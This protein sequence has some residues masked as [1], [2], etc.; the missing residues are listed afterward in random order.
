MKF[1]RLFSLFALLC[2]VN[3]FAAT[4]TV[5][6]SVF[7][8]PMAWHGTL[9]L[10]PT[11]QARLSVKVVELY[12]QQMW[13]TAQLIYIVNGK[14]TQLTLKGDCYASATETPSI[15][16]ISADTPASAVL[17][18]NYL[19]TN[20]KL[21]VGTG[22]LPVTDSNNQPQVIGGLQGTLRLH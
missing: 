15:R 17:Y 4:N 9:S 19:P 1:T 22:M 16:L 20:K 8:K 2:S 14:R 21:R 6:C 3:A 13:K 11:V 10:Q 12:Q 5:L 7:A 18:I